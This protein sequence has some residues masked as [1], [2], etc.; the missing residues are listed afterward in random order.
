MKEKSLIINGL[1]AENC[2]ECIKHIKFPNL[3]ELSLN[4]NQIATLECLPL[5]DLRS[6]TILSLNNN[7][8]TSISFLRKVD[9][10][11]LKYLDIA[12]N[13]VYNLEMISE[14]KIRS[15]FYVSA[16]QTSS[17]SIDLQE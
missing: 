2:F 10:E 8:L 3:K 9:S 5:T 17:R 6:L 1:Y 13:P 15:P 4:S 12:I 16:C 14:V 7:L 11:G